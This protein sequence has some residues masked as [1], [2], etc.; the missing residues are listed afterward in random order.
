MKYTAFGEIRDNNGSSPT[1]Y[2][3]KLRFDFKA[4]AKCIRSY[5]GQRK[6][7]EFGLSYYVTRWYDPEPMLS[8][9]FREFAS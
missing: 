7:V 1:D 5:T 6:K 8:I 9:G 2:E 3:S 4:N